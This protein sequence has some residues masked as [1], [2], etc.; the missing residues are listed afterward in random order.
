[1]RLKLLVILSANPFKFPHLIDRESAHQKLAHG[2]DPMDTIR[3]GIQ[4]NSH[5]LLSHF[6]ATMPL[7]GL[8]IIRWLATPITSKLNFVSLRTH[9]KPLI[10]IGFYPVVYVLAFFKT[11]NNS[12][13]G[14]IALSSIFSRYIE[15]IALANRKIW[16]QLIRFSK[17]FM[18][19]SSALHLVQIR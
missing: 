5:K 7:I 3:E 13:Q 8:G 10:D 15:E 16:T 18:P 6:F 9:T 1:M 12:M 4:P 19:S 17:T 11:P 14:R 2:R